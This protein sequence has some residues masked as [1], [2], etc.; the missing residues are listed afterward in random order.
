MTKINQWVSKM[1]S[2]TP[3]S[4][5]SVV[6]QVSVVGKSS[7]HMV[8]YMG[9]NSESS[10]FITDGTCPA[11]RSKGHV[12]SLKTYRISFSQS[13]FLCGNSQCI[14]PLGY[15]PLDNI[16]ANTADL[17]KH[18]I[19]TKSRKR[20]ILETSLTSNINA[21]KLKI[22]APL[23]G[24]NLPDDSLRRYE[25]L[26]ASK[27][28]N[29]KPSNCQPLQ[30]GAKEDRMLQ[31]QSTVEMTLRCEIS[32]L[33]VNHISQSAYEVPL[34]ELSGSQDVLQGIPNGFHEGAAQDKSLDVTNS[35]QNGF[36][37]CLETAK[38]PVCKS[39]S[40]HRILNVH[41]KQESQETCVK[42]EKSVDVNKHEL[43]L[44]HLLKE[45]LPEQQNMVK[46]RTL[47]DMSTPS[48]N[49]VEEN[50]LQLSV[51][52]GLNCA[53]AAPGLLVPDNQLGEL[54]TSSCTSFLQDTKL[55][56]DAKTALTEDSTGKSPKMFE[57]SSHAAVN[58]CSLSTSLSPDPHFK[59]QVEEMEMS[60]TLTN[61]EVVERD[62]DINTPVTE[63]DSQ[64]NVLDSSL[65]TSLS[66]D[67]LPEQQVEESTLM[68]TATSLCEEADIKNI[69]SMTQVIS[70]SESLVAKPPFFEQRC[71]ESIIDPLSTCVLESTNLKQQ[72]EVMSGS[73][74]SETVH[75]A[76]SPD[77]A[78]KG[79]EM[80]LIQEERLCDT[81]LPASLLQSENQIDK[82]TLNEMPCAN[83]V[84][85][86][87][88]SERVMDSSLMEC[89]MS[90]SCSVL[91]DDLNEDFK[92]IKQD[93][94][95]EVTDQECI[96]SDMADTCSLPGQLT[97]EK[98][99]QK[100][101]GSVE[102]KDSLQPQSN[103][104]K[105]SSPT[106]SVQSDTHHNHIQWRNKYSLCWLDC[107]MS[108]LVHLTTLK[109]NVSMESADENSSVHQLYKK[110]YEA[111]SLLTSSVLKS[112]RGVHESPVFAFPLLLQQDPAVE[113]LFV[114]SFYWKFACKH[115]GHK[116]K[117]KCQKTL[118]TFT[119]ISQEWHPLNAVHR[120]PCNNCQ[121]SAQERVMVLEKIHSIFMLHFVEGLPHNDLNSYSFQFEEYTYKVSAVIQYQANHFS[122]WIKNDDS[123]L[124]FDDLNGPFCKSHKSFIVPPAEIHI[125]IWERE[126]SQIT[127]GKSPCTVD[128]ENKSCTANNQV[129]ASPNNGLSP[130]ACNTLP[131]KSVPS[132]AAAM[133]SDSNWLSGME[134]YADDDIITLTLV[135]IPVDSQGNPIEDNVIPDTPIPV[136]QVQS[137]ATGFPTESF[138]GNAP[139]DTSNNCMLMPECMGEKQSSISASESPPTNTEHLSLAIK[140]INPKPVANEKKD[141]KKSAISDKSSANGF[142]CPMPHSTKKGVVGSWMKSLLNKNPSF[143]NTSLSCSSKKNPVNYQK[144]TPLLKTTDVNVIAKKAENFGGFKVKGI[145]KNKVD[146]N[147]SLIDIKNNSS[148]KLPV[149][150]DESSTPLGTFLVPTVSKPLKHGRNV[151]DDSK[152]AANDTSSNED[153]IRKLRV[154]LLKKLK[155]KKHE[156]ASLEM[157]AKAQSNKQGGHTNPKSHLNNSNL[158]DFLQELQDHI[159]NVDNE[160]VCTMSSS[161]SICSSPGDAEFFAELFSPTADSTKYASDDTR[162]LEMLADGYS[163]SIPNH[164][165]HSSNESLHQIQEHDY[166]MISMS[167]QQDKSE[168][169][170]SLKHNSSDS[171][172]GE[173]TVSDFLSQSAMHLLNTDEE[174][175]PP[176]DDI[177]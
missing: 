49:D 97:L 137:K 70:P 35:I 157:T 64:E 132:N 170:S 112:K 42:M 39:S 28:P 118:T 23:C 65:S 52:H 146:S 141:D 128:T 43:S 99:L 147:T 115:C 148:L 120:A 96:K 174:Y 81:S 31:E 158:H 94:V 154:K 80:V 91:Q 73:L 111:S 124:E 114:C 7:L 13:I 133:P 98:N 63:H 104:V 9:K 10:T 169:T 55:Q 84:P 168:N 29:E 61:G 175:F 79:P 163:S 53:V 60:N 145:V 151:L 2:E 160:S 47:V 95:M 36:H 12:Q 150:K 140:T 74:C 156:L 24:L 76:L 19:S 144:L 127:E 11:C 129:L 130:T 66:Q 126:S 162:F 3:G 100:P 159:D 54:N 69:N 83:T 164:T 153:K 106:N 109:H 1:A 75:V 116:Q 56:D 4:T 108:A 87:S 155:A 138:S 88:K 121:N 72:P 166:T 5:V 77:S 143:L 85:D 90:E 78:I 165:A 37:V 33:H 8:G 173:E 136:S 57:S 6:G 89:E 177:F 176:F 167:L 20:S 149:P 59:Q 122:T 142:S 134:G 68:E 30:N 125:V 123:W 103:S 46:D 45:N 131:A 71:P 50:S 110:Y 26:K 41:E 58:D 34:C 15:T 135:E 93:E 105:I 113:K 119:N 40:P 152:S 48:C 82:N 67:I 32:G 139:S 117:E 25:G 62:C 44:A 27:T 102:N 161:T 101:T 107:I 17:Q 51:V 171:S 86:S 22:D 172:I 16:I 18:H 21:K 14:Y 92:N 38:N